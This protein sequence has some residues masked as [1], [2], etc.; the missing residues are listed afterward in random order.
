MA[1]ILVTGANGFVGQAVCRRLGAAGNHVVAAI[2]PGR[3][4]PPGVTVRAAPDLGADADWRPLL[5]GVDAV[6]HL[7]AR[8]HVMRDTA[9]DPLAQFRAANTAATRTLAEQALEQ[10]VRRFV[11]MSTIKV[12]GET[13]PPDRPFTADGPAAPA[14]PYGVSKFEAEQA[15]CALA[16]RSAMTVAVVRPPLVYGPGVKGNLF[17]L[18]AAAARGLP[19][20]VPATAN[21][22]SLV[23]AANLADLVAACLRPLSWPPFQVF[24]VK[25][26]DISTRDLARCV[27]DAMAGRSL[28]IPLPPTLLTLAA[29]LV[30]R[31]GAAERMTGSLM[32]DDTATRRALDWQ[33][34]VPFADGLA[35]M[36]AAFRAAR[37]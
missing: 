9:R 1:T 35:D 25:D 34:P 37:R 28:A 23:G 7:A 22:R 13:T 16:E 14:D 18:M 15:L 17:R 11:F 27:A 32:V 10:G 4:A 31:R 19:L 8:V 20:P 5:A 21:V 33:P 3:P 6:I 36:V 24:L 29:T 12:N 30:G 2:R 26:V